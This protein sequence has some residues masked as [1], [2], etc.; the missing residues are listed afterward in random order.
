MDTEKTSRV[1]SVCN[2]SG[3]NKRGHD[4]AMARQSE[5]PQEP[6]K[7]VSASRDSTKGRGCSVCGQPGHNKKTHDKVVANQANGTPQ[8]TSKKT[9]VTRDLNKIASKSPKKEKEG[10]GCSVCGQPGHNKRGHD[11][12]MA[13]QNS[14]SEPVF[15]ST[16]QHKCSVCGDKGHNKRGHDKA[17]GIVNMPHTEDD[18]MSSSAASTDSLA[19]MSTKDVLQRI[20][21]EKPMEEVLT[22]ARSTFT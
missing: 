20:E 10:R 9:S 13:N 6:S 11:K 7:K 12:F 4:K 15:V 22:D 19:T 5:N 1:C 8:G 16:G 3:H 14:D 21:Q 2:Q 18:D 17:V